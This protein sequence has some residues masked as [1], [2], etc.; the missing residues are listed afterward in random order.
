MKRLSSSKRKACPG[1][2]D[3]TQALE[4]RGPGELP[5]R[6]WPHLSSVLLKPP[7]KCCCSPWRIHPLHPVCRSETARGSFLIFP[8]PDPFLFLSRAKVIPDP[9]L[10]GINLEFYPFCGRYDKT[11]SAQVCVPFQCPEQITNLKCYG[12]YKVPIKYPQKAMA[13]HSST[14]A[15]KIPWMEEPDRLQSMGLLRVGHD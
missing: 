4:P 15:W 9:A 12:I 2:R 13:P 10:L 11:L 6:A 7:S 5:C 8:I 1:E 14:L 3:E